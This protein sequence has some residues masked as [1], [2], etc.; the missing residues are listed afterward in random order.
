MRY[1]NGKLKHKQN[2]YYEAMLDLVRLYLSESR[3][4]YMSQATKG[5]LQEGKF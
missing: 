5:Q 2:A 3:T 1:S 4:D